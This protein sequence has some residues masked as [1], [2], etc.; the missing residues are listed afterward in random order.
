LNGCL[1]F[2]LLGRTDLALKIDSPIFHC[3]PCFG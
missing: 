2:D 1:P 3:L